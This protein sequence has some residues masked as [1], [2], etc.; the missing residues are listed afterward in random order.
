MPFACLLG[1]RF[2]S[3]NS[4]VFGQC[5][6]NIREKIKKKTK[7]G[8]NIKC[9]VRNAYGLLVSYEFMTNVWLSDVSM[10]LATKA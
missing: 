6:P 3:V 8:C 10:P 5:R 9:L 1:S 2:S 7:K 4:V